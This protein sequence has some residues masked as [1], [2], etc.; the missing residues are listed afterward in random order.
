[1][2]QSFLLSLF[3]PFLLGFTLVSDSEMRVT[4]SHEKAYE[5]YSSNY[6]CEEA[7]SMTTQFDALMDLYNSTGGNSGM[8]NNDTNWGD[9]AVSFDLWHG[10]GTL[11][12][13]NV[14]AI[15]LAWNNLTGTIPSSIDDLVHISVLNL[16]NNNI[17]GNI[18]STIGNLAGLT[19]LTLQNNSISGSIPSTIGNLG[20][21]YDLNLGHNNLSGSIP[22]TIG[23]LTQMGKLRVNNNFLSGSIPN[24]IGNL[25]FMFNLDLSYNNLIG[26]IPSSMESMT[27]ASN[28][29]LNNNSL[30][31]SI[32]ALLDFG[33]IKLNDNNL[34]GG[35]P[36][37]LLEFGGCYALELQNNPNLG[38]TI[39]DIPNSNSA[40][41]SFIILSNCGLSGDIPPTL[42]DKALWSIDIS[43]NS[44]TGIIPSEFGNMTPYT[45]AT[46]GLY[47]QNN[48]L[49]GCFPQTFYNNYCPLSVTV[50]ASN[51]PN[52]VEDDYSVFCTNSYTT[53]SST[54]LPDL[55][56][57]SVTLPS[58][59]FE[60]GSANTFDFSVKNI[61]TANAGASVHK[62][63]LSSDQI[64]SSSEELG[65]FPLN[66]LS[67]NSTN[68]VSN[69]NFSIPSNLSPGDYY[70]IVKADANSQVNELDETNNLHIEFVS[71]VPAG[72]GAI[73]LTVN[74]L[75]LSSN[76]VPAG[77][78]IDLDYSIA[79]IGTAPAGNHFERW[80][81]SSDM[82][83]DAYEEIGSVYVTYLA[84]G[85]VYTSTT[86]TV[87]I[88]ASLSAGTYYLILKADAD[89]DEIE[90][91]ETNNEYIEVIT[92]TN[93][94]GGGGGG[95]G[96]PELSISNMILSQTAIPAGS[97]VTLDFSILN[98][99]SG[100]AGFFTQK[101]YLST[102][103]T[104][105][106]SEEIDSYDIYSL[107]TGTSQSVSNRYITIDVNQ[108]QTNYNIILVT[109]VNNE[110]AE[111]NENNNTSI[112]PITVIA[113][114]N[115]GPSLPDYVII[116]EN[117]PSEVG[118]NQDLYISCK[119]SNIGPGDA[120][121]SSILRWGI[122]TDTDPNN[123]FHYFTSPASIPPLGSNTYRNGSFALPSSVEVDS[124]YFIIF[125]A[126][127][128]NGVPE[129]DETNN[130]LAIPITILPTVA[131]TGIELSNQISGSFQS[132]Y[133]ENETLEVSSFV[134][135][136][137]QN[138][139]EADIA[140]LR[141]YLSSNS[142]LDP[143]MD[144]QLALDTI[145][146]LDGTNCT[147]NC[148]NDRFVATSITIPETISTGTYY[149]ISFADSNDILDENNEADNVGVKLINIVNTTYKPN[150]VIQNPIIAS[151]VYA[152]QMLSSNVDVFNNGL[153]AATYSQV[154][155]YLSEDNIYD[156][157]DIKLPANSSLNFSPAIGYTPILPI[158]SSANIDRN[159]FI[160][161]GIAPGNY[162][163]ICVADGLF[164]LDELYENDN[165]VS[166]PILIG[167]IPD[168]IISN[169]S[170]PT[171]GVAGGELLFTTTV[172]NQGN[173]FALPNKMRGYLSTDR[174]IDSSDFLL[175]QYTYIPLLHGGI[176]EIVAGNSGI[177][178][179]VPPG[180]YIIIIFADDDN[181]VIELN[182]M[183]N[184]NYSI[185]DIV[186][187]PDLTISG[188]NVPTNCL[189][190]D[191][192]IVNFNVDNIGS[193]DAIASNSKVFISTDDIYDTSDEELGTF[194][195]PSL[196]SNE[197]E[198]INSTLTIPSTYNAGSYYLLMLADFD[199]VITNEIDES[200]NIAISEIEVI[201]CQ[202]E[203]NITD[204][205]ICSNESYVFYGLS[206]NVSG[207]YIDSTLLPTGCYL[208]DTLNLLVYS[209]S[210]L[211]IEEDICEGDSI[212]WNGTPYFTQGEYTD[213]YST[214]NGCDSTVTLDLT[215]YPIVTTMV[216]ENI[217]EGDSIFWSGSHYLSSGLYS[218]TL[219]TINNCDSIINLDL[220][221][222]PIYSS[223]ITDTIS[224]GETYDWNGGSYDSTGF[225]TV[226]LSAIN[227]CDSIANLDLTVTLLADLIP[228]NPLAP[229]TV[230][231]GESIIVGIETKNIGGASADVLFRDGYY[232]SIDTIYDH[233]VDVFKGQT[234]IPSLAPEESM[235]RQRWIH[236]TNPIPVGSY[237]IIFRSD[238]INNIEEISE[239]NNYTYLPIEVVCPEVTSTTNA[240]ICEGEIYTFNG[241]DYNTTGTYTDTFPIL[242]GCDSLAILNLTV[243]SPSIDTTEITISQGETYDWNGGSYDS[244]GFY[245]VTLSAINGCDS[246]ANLDLTV[247][248]LADFIAFNTT[249]PN[250][251]EKGSSVQIGFTTKNIGSADAKPRVLLGYYLSTDTIYDASDKWR[252]GRNIKGGLDAGSQ[253]VRRRP[254]AISTSDQEGSYYII[255]RADRLDEHQEIIE[256]N[257]FAYH[258]IEIVCPEISNTTNAE[259]CDGESYTF[260][261]VDY[262]LSGVYTDSL[263]ILNGCDS[264]DILSLTVI[265]ID[266]THYIDTINEGEVYTIESS[267]YTESG[268][269]C[270]VSGT[271]MANGCD[272][273]V[274][275]DL[276]VIPVGCTE[277]STTTIETICANEIYTFNGV[278]YNGTGLY[279]DTLIASNNCDSITILDLTVIA[280]SY[281]N[282]DTLLCEGELFTYNGIDYN[283]SQTIVEDI[284]ASSGCDSIV[285][286]N[287]AFEPLAT[288]TQEVSICFGE[289]YLYMGTVYS[290][291]GIYNFTVSNPNSILCDS[292]IILD[293]TVLS[294]VEST[295][296]NFNNA[297]SIL[298]N[299]E[300]Y[301]A[302]AT[303]NPS[304]ILSES[305][306]SG[307]MCG[308]LEYQWQYH[309]LGSNTFIDVA[310]ETSADLDPDAIS[311]NTCYVRQARMDCQSDWVASN[312][313]CFELNYCENFSNGGTISYNGDLITNDSSIDPGIIYESIIPEGGIGLSKEYQW[314]EKEGSNGWGDIA[315]AVGKD[316]S[317]SSI[318]NNTCFR[319]GVKM[320]CTSLWQY[321]NE[322]CFEI[323]NCQDISSVNS[324]SYSG[325][326]S[327]QDFMYDPPPMT[328]NPVN[329]GSG[330]V[331]EIKWESRVYANPNEWIEIANET[332]SIFDSPIINQSNCFRYAAKM[333]C[334]NEWLYATEVCILIESCENF[335]DSGSLS[336]DGITAFAD[337]INPE[338]ILGTLPLNGGGGKTEFKWEEQIDNS[339]TWVEIIG[340]DAEN[341]D[342]PSFTETRCF[343]RK[344]RVDCQEIWI[345]T[346]EVCFFNCTDEVVS[347]VN[348]EGESQAKSCQLKDLVIEAEKI[349]L[350]PEIKKGSIRL[351]NISETN[352]N[353]EWS[354]GQNTCEIKNLD[355]GI[356]CVTISSLVHE[357]CVL[358]KCF[359]L[360]N[361]IECHESSSRPAIII[362]EISNSKNSSEFIELLVVGNNDCET[363]DL[364]NY[365]IDDNNGLFSKEGHL[366]VSG[367]SK[368]HIR[369]SKDD[370]YSDVP[371]GSIL[372][373]YN[374]AKLDQNLLLTADPFDL[375]NDNKFIIPINDKLALL[376]YP[377]FPNKTTNT[378]SNEELNSTPASWNNLWL[379]DYA[380]A[381]QIRNPEGTY[382][383]GVSYGSPIVMTGGPDNLLL[384]QSNLI[385][386][387]ISFN[388]GDYYNQNNYSVGSSSEV[389]TPGRPNNESNENYIESLCLKLS[390]ESLAT[391]IS[392]SVF[393]N[394]FE[395]DFFIESSSIN[396]LN[397]EVEVFDLL[398]KGIMNFKIAKGED[399]F[400]FELG[401]KLQSG[402]YFLVIKHEEKTLHNQKIICIK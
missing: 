71:I 196:L 322:I 151:T 38:G 272:S 302:D 88:D 91:D 163:I 300:T 44:L 11:N 31:G 330:G 57:N 344:A 254:V 304:L 140:E 375:N 125:R 357:K 396:S 285:T 207:T 199:D 383:F 296:E 371:V 385:D 289:S 156:N 379:F 351:L 82:T 259:I 92:V 301:I 16:K 316:Y 231:I 86:Q 271:P 298:Y 170:V 136:S 237:Y 45:D 293:L 246:I 361:R 49:S 149:I 250:I 350:C 109:D 59:S 376:G 184:F 129:A 292:L 130:A 229:S 280:N 315:N 90:S 104:P 128:F 313:I 391:N 190:G 42:A 188:V 157:S 284:P 8:W 69:A 346:E 166:K 352:F 279:Q 389:G 48:N 242:I 165:F 146:P 355:I 327:I 124:T 214:V 339:G 19:Y 60:A 198:V 324:I 243:L 283:S 36:Q 236:F 288:I 258:P 208:V 329:N 278:D 147:T 103:A 377:N 116:D 72:T 189:S 141:I 360:E 234:W 217:C 96:A 393:P 43:N 13:N 18:P 310:G 95:G 26:S 150:L 121:N 148:D 56:V 4:H 30:S 171:Q 41:L 290:S 401:E 186:Q 368:G 219:N 159:L 206:Y 323:T 211:T 127:G 395:N 175:D 228:T 77:N 342:P 267:S 387:V 160:P 370:R 252:G 195:I 53:C 111:S 192:C 167:S 358:S 101:W 158:D 154:F 22:A 142:N 78:N 311:E 232:L 286:I 120:V 61:G 122:S 3:L 318:T 261:G 65:S 46:L 213:N 400:K 197:K 80:Y 240:E 247:A 216:V 24:S 399:K 205:T 139:L 39:P 58:N 110:I 402:T 114:V 107:A 14:E 273:T 212:F 347:S 118:I 369:F 334:S 89:N 194:A 388:G 365:I 152:G 235:Y 233:G 133:N 384:H 269:Y 115:N 100:D 306:P 153:N 307:G 220:T 244:T 380:D 337:Q 204:I 17:S 295:C 178:N 35:I 319:R 317:P 257:N 123:I 76:N 354:K 55:K 265:A 28:I 397:L 202:N 21:L 340:A 312:E 2:K 179:N 29:F 138:S 161:A 378:Y 255:C 223:I 155:Y 94:G 79:N 268:F 276:T 356:Y 239:E 200:N 81:L 362:N 73:D 177:P 367:I 338:N 68:F 169:V 328:S 381:V 305:T 277:I 5:I 308:E 15:N 98:S 25:S 282:L 47:F 291:S 99:G 50:D 248:P 66:S 145:P 34:I 105:Q 224:Q 84:S 93:A 299:E 326:L 260:N 12:S 62:W 227:G 281:L 335:S 262:S 1:M 372:L 64:P 230:E 75:T 373:I 143:L 222:L 164:Q 386:K 374:P 83:A 37:S 131:L 134:T 251:A 185:I 20:N 287:L 74:S 332:S 309:L 392:F 314:Q 203:S 221:V 113:P 119:V 106:A 345:E 215:V 85:A 359:E 394:P 132:V 210:T 181:E 54:N 33:Y 135:N 349:N 321:S 320:T 87:S 32:P 102:D 303:H 97:T 108:P 67:T 218:D 63:Y 333:S 331:L 341:Y 274:C 40:T 126:D 176:S 112:I 27:G 173:T 137:G 270:Q 9:A 363:V 6:S 172:K 245:T 10:V 382:H 325:S 256:S 201:T 182:E 168:L 144:I 209:T 297:G 162:F 7:L 174:K 187:L 398:G 52:M 294:D 263:P 364:R 336:Y 266:T 183:N 348:E 390:E 353:I 366:K 193:S 191:D 249:G 226:T 343:R 23:S 180:Q 264:I 51:N 225:Y 275:V 241:V 70:F 253:A 238:R 117:V